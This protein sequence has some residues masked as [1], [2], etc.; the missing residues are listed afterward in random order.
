MAAISRPFPA[1]CGFWVEAGVD[2]EIPTAKRARGP[3][4]RRS[5]LPGGTRANNGAA[6]ADPD[7]FFLALP[8][9]LIFLRT[10]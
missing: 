3:A 9:S 4:K 6:G 8:N 7:Q 5:A 2:D 10:G 1:R